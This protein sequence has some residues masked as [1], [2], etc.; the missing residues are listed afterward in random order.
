MGHVIIGMQHHPFDYLKR[1][2]QQSTQRRLEEACHLFHCGHLHQPDATQ[3]VTRSG[4]CLTLSA[5]A[6]FESRRLGKSSG[7]VRN[8]P[9]FRCL[10]VQRRKAIPRSHRLAET[11]PMG[12]ASCRAF[13]ARRGDATSIKLFVQYAGKLRF[14]E[15]RC[16]RLTSPLA[17]YRSHNPPARRQMGDVEATDAGNTPISPGAALELYVALTFLN[18]PCNSCPQRV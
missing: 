7:S 3:A 12:S 15:N 17:F 9:R 16:A 5:G 6:S 14:T 2:D 1:F 11:T 13:S 10:A 4:K 8:A 18:A